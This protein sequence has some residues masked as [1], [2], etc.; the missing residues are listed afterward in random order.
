MSFVVNVA[1]VQALASRGLLTLD[2]WQILWRTVE[3]VVRSNP[4]LVGRMRLG[5]DTGLPGAV[6]D[7]DDLVM[8]RAAAEALDALRSSSASTPCDGGNGVSNSDGAEKHKG[9]GTDVTLPP[10]HCQGSPNPV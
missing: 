3:P 1:S 10:P 7:D 8:M 4:V 6:P 2:H 9:Y 5:R